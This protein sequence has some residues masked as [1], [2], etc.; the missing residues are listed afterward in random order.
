M[1]SNLICR[2]L[3]KR[4]LGIANSLEFTYTRYADDMTFSSESY[5]K[6]NKMM[7]WI[8]G[9]TKEEG[10]VL[11]PKKTK[12]MKRGA[13]HEVTGVVVNE[14]LSIN[15]KELKKFR[16]LLYQIEQSG[17][18]GKSWNGKSENL[19]ASIWGYANFIQMVDKEKGAKYMVQVKA[20]L[21]KYPMANLGGSNNEFREKSAK[22]ESF[23]EKE[24]FVEQ[25][26]ESNK[27]QELEEQVDAPSFVN[28]I[29]NMFRK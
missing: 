15:R 27:S 11:H 19:M 6:I 2:K 13:R 3:D 14:K 10:F 29:L 17:L 26:P 23:Y 7:Y 16:A 9:I 21:E 28:N 20:L 12:I 1:I 22:G 25:E 8:K 4:M 5:E 18:E 24:V